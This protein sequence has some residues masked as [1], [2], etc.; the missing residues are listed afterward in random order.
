ME[1]NK[2]QQKI[3]YLYKQWDETLEKYKGPIR[4]TEGIHMNGALIGIL[5]IICQE[6]QKAI[7]QQ[8]QRIS[9]LER[10]IES[11]KQEGILPRDK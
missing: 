11:C 5:Y 7:T 4:D 2:Q 1:D 3:E 10:Y 9:E 8:Q 6:Q